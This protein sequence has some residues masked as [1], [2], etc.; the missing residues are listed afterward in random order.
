M[1]LICETAYFDIK[2]K[3]N[4]LIEYINQERVKYAPAEVEKLLP[5]DEHLMLILNPLD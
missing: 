3:M 5:K 1:R 2:M 4:N